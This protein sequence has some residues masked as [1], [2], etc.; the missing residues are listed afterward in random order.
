MKLKTL[1]IRNLLAIK[2]ATVEFDENGVFHIKGRNNVGKSALLKAINILWNN[3]NQIEVKEFLRDNTTTFVLDA[4]MHDGSTVKLSRGTTDYYVWNILG[5]EG[6]LDK[7]KGK[8]P[9]ILHKYYNLY[10][11]NERTHECLNVRLPR[12]ILTFVDTTK[13][14]TYYL[15]QKALRT[16]EYILAAQKAE[17]KKREITNSQKQIKQFIERD[18]ARI[19]QAEGTLTELKTQQSQ[20]EQGMATLEHEYAIFKEI[21]AIASTAQA[22]SECDRQILEITNGIDIERGEQLKQEI[23]E[24]ELIQTTIN[25]MVEAGNRKAQILALRQEIEQAEELSALIQDFEEINAMRELTRQ[26]VVSTQAVTQKKLEV[27]Q[28]QKTHMDF[29]VENKFCPIV[30]GT[31]DQRCPFSINVGGA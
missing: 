20:I 28:A 21:E 5:V 29:M 11:D 23:E 9:E 14:E 24:F 17:A 31:L 7:T 18:Q 12:D 4:E 16:E 15:V 26:F 8:V 2:D 27:E 19:T 25:M 1:R 3:V 6:R 30:M 13:T 10:T 22:L